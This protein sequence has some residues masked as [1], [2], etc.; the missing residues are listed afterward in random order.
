MRVESSRSLTARSM[1]SD[2]VLCVMSIFIF[3][4]WGIAASLSILN[5]DCSCGPIS[6]HHLTDSLTA[7]LGKRTCH[8]PIL[9]AL[10]VVLDFALNCKGKVSADV[11]DIGEVERLCFLFHG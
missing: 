5:F 3:L 2:V 4:L 6:V 8:A 7:R 11:A 9:A 10:L 1:S